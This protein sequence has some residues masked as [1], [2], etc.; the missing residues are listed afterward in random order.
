MLKAYPWDNKDRQS[1]CED[2]V[3]LRSTNARVVTGGERLSDTTSA[4][5]SRVIE[6]RFGGYTVPGGC[7][8]AVR[9]KDPQRLVRAVLDV[10]E[11][12]QGSWTVDAAAA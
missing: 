9:Q 5:P 2:L 1:S 7:T 10:T 4:R 6:E 11:P 12:A 8:A 3:A